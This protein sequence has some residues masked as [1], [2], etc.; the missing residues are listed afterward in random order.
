[1]PV[2]SALQILGI[3]EETEL[4]H[5]GSIVATQ[6]KDYIQ[7]SQDGASEKTAKME[8]EALRTLYELFFEYAL[9]WVGTERKKH[10]KEPNHPRAMDLRK[11][12]GAALADLQAG[13]IKY[14]LCYMRL[15]RSAGIIQKEIETTTAPMEKGVEWTAESSI[16]LGRFRK[17]KTALEASNLRL[18]KGMALLEPF[19]ADCAAFEE[20]CKTFFG[21]EAAE[22]LLRPLRASLRAQDFARAEKA[23]AATPEAKTRFGV[24][25]GKVRQAM[26]TLVPRMAAYIKTFSSQPETF[27]SGENKLFLRGSEIR[28]VVQAQEKEI[29]QRRAFI[30]KYHQPYLHHKKLALAHLREKLLVIGSIESLMTL[31]IRMMR[32]FALPM[33]DEKAVREYEHMV[34]E[35]I[36]YLMGGQF[37]EIDRIEERNVE[38]MNEFRQSVESYK[39]N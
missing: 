31:Y 19:E 25:K 7:K 23:L 27:M 24:D 10:A 17:E 26:D 29:E 3:K 34:L 6:V 37:Q 21:D 39:K 14:A 20:A 4:G 35:N 2:S 5:A 18:N 12:A 16:L 13:M 9:T 11:K 30:H 33:K 36:D 32:G 15:G 1:M 22:E 28:L 38:A 8:E